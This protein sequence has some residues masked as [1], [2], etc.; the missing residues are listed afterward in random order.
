MNFINIKNCKTIDINDIPKLNLQ[1]FHKLILSFCKQSHRPLSLY[2]LSRDKDIIQL[3]CILADDSI[4]EL[5]LFSTTMKSGDKYPSLTLHYPAFQMLERDLWERYNIIPEGHPWLK[6]LRYCNKESD[7][8][9]YKF[10]EIQSEQIHQIGVGP[11]HAGIIEPGHF[12]FMCSGEKV[13]HLELQ[14]GYQHRGIEKIIINSPIKDKCRIAESI[15]GDSVIAN[16]YAYAQLTESLSNIKPNTYINLIRA[17]ALEM[18]RIAIHIGDLSALANDIAYQPAS[19]YL[20]AFRTLIINSLLKISGS[21]FGRGL[22]KVGGVNYNI[23]EILVDD[24]IKTHKK[25]FDAVA[26]ILDIFFTQPSVLSRFEHTGTIEQKT[27][28]TIG[29]KGLSARASGLKTDIRSDYPFGIYKEL[30]YYPVSWDSGDVFARSYIRFL[31]I[32]QSM[33]FIH[34]LLEKITNSKNK[35][36]NVID[37][38]TKIS[39]KKNALC[40][41][42]IEA[43]RGELIHIASTNEKG[44]FDNY[45]IIDPSVNNWYALALALREEGISDFPL[46]NKSFNLSYC[47]N[48]L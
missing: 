40:I 5:K 12:R 24:L 37:E 22:M 29:L 11:V 10:F 46:C 3:V 38:D 35:Q 1:D 18:E 17:L 34:S 26:E 28:V 6:P 32:K 41:S 14:L 25:V 48:D 45:N 33:K 20:G 43:W 23:D 2:G 4:S 31:E 7:M 47:G 8:S 9:T 36:I 27:A 30:P 13:K 44:E 39:M 21:R 16:S 42:L 19:S 15:C